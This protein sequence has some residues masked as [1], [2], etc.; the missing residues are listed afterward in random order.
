MG[1]Y[2]AV[3]QSGAELL[4]VGLTSAEALQNKVRQRI[5]YVYGQLSRLDFPVLSLL[6]LLVMFSKLFVTRRC[7]AHSNHESLLRDTC[8]MMW[9]AIRVSLPRPL[10][11]AVSPTR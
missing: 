3:Y 8:T 7:S 9:C 2:Y 10:T 1:E 5:L 11:I 6:E 4:G